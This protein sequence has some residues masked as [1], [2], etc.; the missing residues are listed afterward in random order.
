MYFIYRTCERL[1]YTSLTPALEKILPELL[2]A[3]DFQTGFDIFQPAADTIEVVRQRRQRDSAANAFGNRVWFAYY[4]TATQA[5][6]LF[7]IEY[8]DSRNKRT[9]GITPACE[10]YYVPKYV[11]QHIEYIAS[12]IKLLTPPNTLL[13]YGSLFKRQCP[14]QSSDGLHT[15]SK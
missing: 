10:R 1:P 4:I 6:D 12:G 3:L 9:G 15:R 7:C 11:Q 14:H 13:E 2:Q 8:L 5:E